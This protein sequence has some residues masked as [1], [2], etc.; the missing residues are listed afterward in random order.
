MMT[1]SISPGWPDANLGPCD[2]QGPRIACPRA[3]LALILE[4]R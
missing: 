1:P 4:E 3:T 2:V